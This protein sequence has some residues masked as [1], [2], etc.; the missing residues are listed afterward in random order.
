MELFGDE[1]MHLGTVLCL[2]VVEIG[3]KIR[4]NF[5]NKSIWT[6]FFIRARDPMLIFEEVY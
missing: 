3:K 4:S 6:C 1:E 2:E 5:Q